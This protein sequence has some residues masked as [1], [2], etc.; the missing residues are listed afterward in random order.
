MNDGVYLTSVGEIPGSIGPGEEEEVQVAF[1]HGMTHPQDKLARYRF[2][3]LVDKYYTARV[4]LVTKGDATPMNDGV[5]YV[6]RLGPNGS[7][8]EGKVVPRVTAAGSV[9]IHATGGVNVTHVVGS[10]N[11][12]ALKFCN[13]FLGASFDA[14]TVK[15]GCE[16][17]RL[18]FL[19]GS[20]SAESRVG[21]CAANKGTSKETKY[22]FYSGYIAPGS[23]PGRTSAFEAQVHCTN[24][25]GTWAPEP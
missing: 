9:Q 8:V 25:R 21:T 16:K 7:V 18:Q 13:E 14:A 19:K 15:K 10:C 24:L 12:V 5:D 2:R 17:S 23:R 3:M 22:S 1:L 6:F 4:S 11:N 20:C